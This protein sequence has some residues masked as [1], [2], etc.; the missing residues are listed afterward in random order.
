MDTFR[1]AAV[2]PSMY[3][4]RIWLSTDSRTDSNILI[5]ITQATRRGSWL[6]QTFSESELHI[7]RSSNT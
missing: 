4:P 1:S 7:K 6:C 2:N 5:I 3:L